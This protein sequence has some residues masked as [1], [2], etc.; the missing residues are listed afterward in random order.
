MSSMHKMD[1]D[2]VPVPDVVDPSPSQQTSGPA[3]QSETGPP[4]KRT[5]G[6]ETSSLRQRDAPTPL[7]GKCS[8]FDILLLHL[9]VAIRALS[10]A[11]VAKFN[12]LPGRWQ[13]LR[14]VAIV[15]TER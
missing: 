10:A 5:T 2:P 11:L 6:A 4:S 14:H 12:I 3:E 1:T 13:H 9:S 7:P 8:H 15:P